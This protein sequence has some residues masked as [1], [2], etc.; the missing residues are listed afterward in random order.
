MTLNHWDN[1]F[2]LFSC[3]QSHRTAPPY[4]VYFYPGSSLSHWFC[5][6]WGVIRGHGSPHCVQFKGDKNGPYKYNVNL[7]FKRLG[8]P[9]RTLKD[10]IYI[11]YFQKHDSNIGLE[12]YHNV[13]SHVREVQRVIW[14]HNWQFLVESWQQKH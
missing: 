13:I 12:A 4:L 14:Y 11:K 8:L 3:H 10:R 9:L 1:E 7:D 6:L 2:Y 5:F